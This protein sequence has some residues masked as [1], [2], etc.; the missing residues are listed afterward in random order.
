MTDS[1]E[2][3]LVFV[4]SLNVL[5]FLGQ[6]AILEINPAASDFYNEEG[7]LLSGFDSGNYTLDDSDP[8]GRL[9]SGEASVSPT[10]GNIFTDTFTSI[11]SWL[12]DSTGLGYVF[13]VLGAPYHLLQFMGLPQAF[14]YAVGTMWYAFTLLLIV[15]FI[16]GRT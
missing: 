16:W 4:L 6:I 14:I 10:T 11:K 5:L 1:L 13:A 7:T 9:P 2:T 3:A 12:I 15:A 8:A